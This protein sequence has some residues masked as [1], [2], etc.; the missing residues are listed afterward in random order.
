MVTR[1][2]DLAM[3]CENNAWSDVFFFTRLKDLCYSEAHLGGFCFIFYRRSVYFFQ[4][5]H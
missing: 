5:V 2:P 4:V 3:F 1:I